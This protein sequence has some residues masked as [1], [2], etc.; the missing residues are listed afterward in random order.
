MNALE[1][2]AVFQISDGMDIPRDRAVVL[3]KG[4]DKVDK[5]L[6][7]QD[8]K[9]LYDRIDNPRDRAYIMYH[10][11]TGLRVRDVVRTEWVHV[12]WQECRTYTYDHK[13]DEWR[14]VYWPESVKP[15]LKMWRLH[16]ESS[17]LKSETLFPFCERTATR[18]LRGWLR[19]LGHPLSE[20]AGS[21]WLR[22]TFVRLSR[23]AG[24]DI[25][26]VQQNTGD[27]LTTILNWYSSLNSEDMREQIEGRP[28]I[29][30]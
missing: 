29:P 23:R 13:K 7:A 24:R 2:P 21:H 6:R 17:G 5:Y 1:P 28:L 27:S 12:K 14:W 26:A 30:G 4:L 3:S 22:H 11:E 9:A 10:A 20:R 19:T 16:M 25:K 15:A 18:I 8:L